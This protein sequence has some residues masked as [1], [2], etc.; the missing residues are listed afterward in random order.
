MNLGVPS[1]E[2]MRAK[3]PFNLGTESKEKHDKLFRG[4][5]KLIF[6]LGTGQ[7]PGQMNL[8]I[9]LFYLD[10]LTL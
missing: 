1:G 5:W 10:F 8:F 4:L 7:Q 6:Y 9:H 3:A 2:G